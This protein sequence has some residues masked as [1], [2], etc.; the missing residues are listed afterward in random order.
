MYR[1]YKD[2]MKGYFDCDKLGIHAIPFS[3]S[4]HQYSTEKDFVTRF[5][6]PPPPLFHSSLPVY[7]KSRDDRRLRR[8]RRKK[9]GTQRSVRSLFTS[10]FVISRDERGRRRPPSKKDLR[11]SVAFPSRGARQTRLG[12]RPHAD[13][14]WMD[15]GCYFSLG[16][17]L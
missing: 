9:E 11:W 4:P 2:K 15:I 1:T 10:Y 7:S 14:C 17:K 16:E 13:N 12:P 3:A 5:I 8:G 6:L